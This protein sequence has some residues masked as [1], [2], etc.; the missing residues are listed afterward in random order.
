M[1]GFKTSKDQDLE[2][3]NATMDATIKL[4]EQR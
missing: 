3:T 4:G 2:R 1:S